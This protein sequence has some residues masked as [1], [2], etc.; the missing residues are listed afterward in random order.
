MWVEAFLHTPWIWSLQL[1]LQLSRKNIHVKHCPLTG[2][3]HN[4]PI[5][6]ELGRM[7]LAILLTYRIQASTSAPTSLKESGGRPENTG[8]YLS[9]R[10]CM[11]L[12]LFTKQQP[13][14]SIKLRHAIKPSIWGDDQSVVCLFFPKNYYFQCWKH[15]H[16][17]TS[18]FWV[19][20]KWRNFGYTSLTLCLLVSKKKIQS[21]TFKLE[22]GHCVCLWGSEHGGIT[23]Q[24]EFRAI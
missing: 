10:K 17:P 9:K 21:H 11:D 22:A 2:A 6:L 16:P 8:S 18:A 23:I 13:Q 20:L 7:I 1:P 5:S 24:N 4:S 14:T 12:F 15:V 19:S 3:M